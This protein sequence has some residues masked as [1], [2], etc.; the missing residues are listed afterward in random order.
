MSDIMCSA[1]MFEQSSS[2]SGSEEGASV[3]GEEEGLGFF[4]PV[5]SGDSENEVVTACTLASTTTLSLYSSLELL[6]TVR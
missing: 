4:Q 3:S 1:A 2:S 5:D 6:T